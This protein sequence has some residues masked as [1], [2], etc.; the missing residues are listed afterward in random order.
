[1]NE[2]ALQAIGPAAEVLARAEGLTA[3]AAA[4]SRRL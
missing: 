2:Q 1:L 4:V 3:H